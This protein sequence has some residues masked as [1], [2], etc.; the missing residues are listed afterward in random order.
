[1]KTQN[2]NLKT[3]DHVHIKL[4]EYSPRHTSDEF[5][6]I[7]V[8]GFLQYSQSQ[9]FIDLCLDISSSLKA[10]VFCIDLRG[11]GESEGRFSFGES[12]YLD[13][14]AAVHFAKQKFKKVKLLGFSLGAYSSLRTHCASSELA[15][16]LYLVSCPSSVTNILWQGH[17]LKHCLSLIYQKQ[18]F[19]KHRN[20]GLRWGNPFTS[21][22]DAEKFAAAAQVPTHFLAGSK[23]FL[24]PPTMSSKIFGAIRSGAKTWRVIEGG[25]HAELLYLSHPKDFKDWLVSP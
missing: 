21:K 17:G 15:D 7:V 6:W 5:C 12:E 1:M 11:T 14:A 18:H 2:H 19:Q 9:T 8:P 13:V 16:E 25:H 4:V 22:P 10:N 23:D 3:S 20:F 24:V